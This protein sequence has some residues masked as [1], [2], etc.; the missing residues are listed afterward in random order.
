[1]LAAMHVTL[2]MAIIMKEGNKRKTPVTACTHL[3]CWCQLESSSSL[4]SGWSPGETLGVSS[5]GFAMCC[6][7]NP[8]EK[9]PV[10]QSLLDHDQPLD[11]EPED[12]GY[13]TG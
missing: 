11:K 10:P 12:S 7:R 8:T 4:A 13:K 6:R 1:M 2:K 3:I 9:I 5:D